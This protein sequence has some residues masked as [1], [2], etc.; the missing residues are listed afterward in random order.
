MDIEKVFKKI[1]HESLLQ[2]IRKRF[3]EQIHQL[4]K[5]YLSSR[6][7]A[8]KIKDIYSEVRHQDRGATRK[9]PRPNTTHIIYGEHTN[10]YQ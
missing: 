9:R 3:P 6:T 10:N 5:Y 4:I 1:N 7:I 8:I 2:T